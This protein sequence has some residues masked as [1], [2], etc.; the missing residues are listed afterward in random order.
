M[1]TLR[2]FAYREHEGEHDEHHR[3]GYDDRNV[4]TGLRPSSTI[5][6]FPRTHF[7]LPGVIDLNFGIDAAVTTSSAVSSGSCR[8]IL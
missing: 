3:R 7:V 6:S 8:F 2:F 4:A 5:Q 1:F